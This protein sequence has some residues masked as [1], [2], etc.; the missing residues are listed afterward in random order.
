M[1]ARATELRAELAAEPP[2]SVLV[3]KPSSLGDIV[4]ALAPVAALRAHWP[5]ARVTWVANPAWAPVL[6]GGGVADTVLPFPRDQFRGAA[7]GLRFLRWCRQLRTLR[8]D[9]VIDLQGLFR[10]AWIAR[11]ARPRRWVGLSDAREGAAFMAPHVA[12]VSG[13]VHAVDRY[14]AAVREIGVPMP[15]QPVFPLPP[16]TAPDLPEGPFVVVHPFARGQGKSLSGPATLALVRALGPGRVVL[17]GRGTPPSE[18]PDHAIDLTNRTDLSQ[19]IGLLRC[20]AFTVSVD[21]GPMHLAAALSPRVLG[22]HGWS[23]PRRVGPYPRKALVWKAGRIWNSD[24]YDGAPGDALP[25]PADMEAIARAVHA[26]L[27]D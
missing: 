22:I 6:E 23:D 1:P 15:G 5:E 3:V 12:N 7:G 9:L 24:A 27:R 21:S 25:G 26:A 17:V 4:H 2:R 18:L 8:P 16:G 14:F 13:A 19:L 20:A 10:S 11:S